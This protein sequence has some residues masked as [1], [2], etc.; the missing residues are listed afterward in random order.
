MEDTRIYA[1]LLVHGAPV[2]VRFDDEEQY[3]DFR[4][5]V[6]VGAEALHQVTGYDNGDLRIRP[7]AVDVIYRGV[8]PDGE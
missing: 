1:C 8:K 2:F 5:W 4:Y 6:N 3:D 7:A